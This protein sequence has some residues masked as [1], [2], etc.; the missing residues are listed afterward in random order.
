MKMTAL[1]VALTLFAGQ[2][3][4]L[5][6]IMADPKRSFQQAADSED[7][8]Y[9]L[10]GTLDFDAALLP[11]GV[12][13]NDRGPAV[14]IPAIFN[15]HSLSPAGFA[16]YYAGEMTLLPTCAGPWCGK[17]APNVASLM[18]A[19]VADGTITI[20]ASPCGGYIFPDPSK[21]VLDEMTACMNGNCN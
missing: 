9:V 5:S 18:F 6:C 20:E 19:K 12:G 11:Q 14:P 3:S 4:A 17:H 15:G 7:T 2:V 21:A 16:S 13:T 1:T 8:Y 10:Y